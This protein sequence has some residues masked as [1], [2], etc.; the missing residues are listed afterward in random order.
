MHR[1]KTAV[2]DYVDDTSPDAELIFSDFRKISLAFSLLKVMDKLNSQ[3]RTGY[4]TDLLLD[5]LLRVI[6]PMKRNIWIKSTD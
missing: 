5:P 3:Y 6:M 1:V 2:N 4:Q